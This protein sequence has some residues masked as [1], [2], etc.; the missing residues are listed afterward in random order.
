MYWANVISLLFI[1]TCVYYVVAGTSV[2]NVDKTQ[3]H[4]KKYLFTKLSLAM[5]ALAHGMMTV[6]ANESIGWFFWALG[7]MSFSLF[8]PIWVDFLSL[9]TGFDSKP[10]RVIVYCLYAFFF[11]TAVLC[12]ATTEVTLI[13]TA[14]GYQ[15]LFTLNPALILTQ[16]S[17]VFASSLIIIMQIRWINIARTRWHRRQAIIFAI[18][19]AAIAPPAIT[20]DLLVPSYF[21]FTIVAGASILI[22][23]ITIPLNSVIRKQRLLNV[24]TSDIADD[25]FSSVNQ[26][27][28]AL[29]YQNRVALANMAAEVF[30]QNDII[31]KNISDLIYINGEQPEPALFD[32]DFS[33][34]DGVT[35]TVNG[36]IKSCSVLLTVTKDKNDDVLS[37]IVILN[38]IT[39]LKNAL[40]KANE[41]SRAKTDFLAKM[42]HEIR[43]PMNAV[44]GLTDLALREE[45]VGTIKEHLQTV[46]QAGQNLLTLI[47]D[48]LDFSKIEANKVEIMSDDYS[49]PTLIN[50]IVSLIRMRLVN[51]GLQFI[52]NVD[53][54]IP[55]TLYGDEM[56]IRQ[57]ILNILSNAVKYTERGHVSLGVYM[58]PTEDD[59]GGAASG[60]GSYR[61]TVSLVIEVKD[62]GRG[63]RPDDLDE[64]N[65]FAVFTQFDMEKNKGIEGVGLG[66]AITKSIVDMMGG[67]IEIKSDYGKGSTF[68]ITLPQKVRTRIPLASVKGIA[69]KSVLIYERRGIY[70]DSIAWSLSNLG[71]PYVF[72]EG[73]TDLYV[74]LRKKK[75]SYLFISYELYKICKRML[76]RPTE[77]T[78][79][80]VLA[81]FGEVVPQED[82][83]VIAMPVYCTS[84]ADIMGGIHDG[85]SGNVSQ[86]GTDEGLTD[87]IAPDA[88]VLVV[89]DIK[90]NLKVTEGILKSYGM[91]ID[92][93]DNGLSAIK[94]AQY[95]FKCGDDEKYDLIFMDH[96]M[97]GIDGIE[98]TKQIRAL[99]EEYFK[100]VPVI[101]LTA[102]AV[103]G[104]EEIFLE[105]G[106]NG[107]LSKPISTVKLN[108]ILEKYIPDEKKKRTGGA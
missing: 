106:F 32:D 90:T 1:V 4:R 49:L 38:D 28:L 63:I 2:F 59:A 18:L 92:L 34:D 82:V 105:N 16:I 17:V 13:P 47:N 65:Q 73:E 41:A 84:I 83:K 86:A 101:A 70:R 76:K 7:F 56:R 87:F 15:F 48:I 20:I 23:F 96:K 75:H 3:K 51:T 30:W 9:F 44:I 40:D 21:D 53:S 62:T 72:A 97:P 68:R 78:A 39:E 77:N 88:K 107:F 81:E 54:N 37:K 71:V 85:I 95:A 55:H 33:Y 22:L 52:V 43:T 108:T 29:D 46:K 6:A 66:L 10:V 57:A 36:E 60:E 8:L 27:I 69:K 99:D 35:V 94:A 19:T 79:I 42:S 12:I 103:V 100:D 45:S 25:I 67:H 26:P 58:L 91:H 14:L 102:N 64:L 5:W 61:D 104:M 89:D 24:T 74:Q 31:G 11:A 50:D 80:I 93:C 98:A